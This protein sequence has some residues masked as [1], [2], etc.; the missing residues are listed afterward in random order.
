MLKQ[1]NFRGKEKQRNDRLQ[2][3]E[4][5]LMLE[6]NN[7]AL[8]A[9]LKWLKSLF[10]E[11]TLGT[12]DAEE[13]TYIDG[14]IGLVN[15]EILTLKRNLLL[16][17]S[18]ENTSLLKQIE[19]KSRKLNRVE[20]ELKQGRCEVETVN[21]KH[22]LMLSE[23]EELQQALLSINTN[24]G[25][26]LTTNKKM[27]E[28]MNDQ[29]AKLQKLT[30]ANEVLEHRC[31][32][33]EQGLRKLLQTTEHS[34]LEFS[35]EFYG[36][37]GNV[38]MLEK[39]EEFIS[40]MKGS[41]LKLDK[42]KTTLEDELQKAD[43]K[44]NR[45]LQ[46]KVES[47]EYESRIVK[48]QQELEIQRK[49]E[50][51]SVHHQL[52][53]IKKSYE[54]SL[55]KEEV[56]AQEILKLQKLGKGKEAKVKKFE[57]VI[58]IQEKLLAD[59]VTYTVI[60]QGSI[61]EM[62]LKV[63][64]LGATEQ[65]LR[66]DLEDHL[67]TIAELKGKCSELEQNERDLRQA[68]EMKEEEIQILNRELETSKKSYNVLLQEKEEVEEQC[69][70]I[71]HSLLQT[72]EKLHE[73]ENEVQQLSED[74]EKVR[75]ERENI[76]YEAEKMK[77]VGK[78]KL[79]K[80][81]KFQEIVV[82][83]ENI[84]SE[85]D[86]DLFMMKERINDLSEKL[87]QKEEELQLLQ[88]DLER[89]T[90]W[91]E[92]CK[93]QERTIHDI[94][95][96]VKDRTREFTEGN[97]ESERKI[98]IFEEKCSALE[99]TI[100]FLQRQEKHMEL[101]IQ[102]LSASSSE[103]D[104]WKT[105]CQRL[106]E[107]NESHL[108]RIP[109]VSD[110]IER[111]ET[112]PSLAI[113]PK[114]QED[115]TDD[116]DP[117]YE[118][119]N[120]KQL[121]I[122]L[123]EKQALILS[124][125]DNHQKELAALNA[126]LSKM[127]TL[128][129]AKDA[130]IAKLQNMAKDKQNRGDENGSSNA[131]ES[132]DNLSL[133]SNVVDNEWRRRIMHSEVVMQLERRILNAKEEDLFGLK[134]RVYG[135][136]DW[137]DKEFRGIESSL[138]AMEK[139]SIEK[140][141][142]IASMK[143]EL[144]YLRDISM[145]EEAELLEGKE[146]DV[147]KSFEQELCK[148]KRICKGKEAK[149]NQLEQ[150]KKDLEEKD[151]RNAEQLSTTSHTTNPT[152]W[153]QL[154]ED[155]QD[156]NQKLCQHI[157]TLN[158]EQL[159]RVKDFESMLS[160]ETNQ[161]LTLKQNQRLAELQADC[162]QQEDKVSALEERCNVILMEKNNCEKVLK[163]VNN[164]YQ[165][166]AGQRE[167]IITDMR[168]QIEEK[169]QQIYILEGEKSRL[170]EQLGT[171]LEVNTKQEIEKV[172][173]RNTIRFSEE[174]IQEQNTR[175]INLD[176]TVEKQ[177]AL[178]HKKGNIAEA[179]Q[180]DLEKEI[181][182]LKESLKTIHEELSITKEELEENCNTKNQ[183]QIEQDKLINLKEEVN[184][185]Y[186]ENQHLHSV[187]GG[188]EQQLWSLQNTCSVMKREAGA[189]N[190]HA[191][192]TFEI[193][194]VV[195]EPIIEI[196]SEKLLG[197]VPSSKPTEL[198]KTSDTTQ[199]L[200]D[201]ANETTEQ[202]GE[203][204]IQ[205][206]LCKQQLTDQCSQLELNLEHARKSQGENDSHKQMVMDRLT[207]AQQSVEVL[208]AENSQLQ[209]SLSERM[210]ELSLLKSKLKNT[211]E[212]I[213]K[214]S[215]IV[216]AMSAEQEQSTGNFRE[217]IETSR[218]NIVNLQEQ[219][220]ALELSENNIKAEC[221]QYRLQVCDLQQ[222][223]SESNNV[224]ESERE[225]FLE[226]EIYL[227]LQCKTLFDEVD[228]EKK[229][230]QSLESRIQSVI[231]ELHQEKQRTADLGKEME[232]LQ[233]LKLA[234][235]ELASSMEEKENILSSL[236]DNKN[237]DEEM[238][239]KK[240]KE[241]DEKIASLLENMQ[242]MEEGL[243][244]L[245]QAD[246]MKESLKETKKEDIETEIKSLRAELEKK[247]NFEN[248][249]NDI[250]TDAG[251][252]KKESLLV[253]ELKQKIMTDESSIHILE[254]KLTAVDDLSQKLAECENLLMTREK[255]FVVIQEE[256]ENRVSE[257]SS[258]SLKL[259]DS[260]KTIQD[261]ETANRKLNDKLHMET[262]RL[263]ENIIKA[264]SQKSEMHFQMVT[265][266]EEKTQIQGLLQDKSE[267]CVKLQ[268]QADQTVK[269]IAT[270]D[271]MIN[272]VE[273]LLEQLLQSNE[274][275]SMITELSQKLK[276][277]DVQ[278]AEKD[279]KIE[280][281]DR[282]KDQLSSIIHNV[283][284]CYREVTG[285]ECNVQNIEGIMI[286]LQNFQLKEIEDS[287]HDL[288]AQVAHLKSTIEEMTE[289]ESVRDYICSDLT[290]AVE[291][292]TKEN[293]ALKSGCDISNA[294]CSKMEDDLVEYKQKYSSLLNE[295]ETYKSESEEEEHL[296]QSSANGRCVET[297]LQTTKEKLK[298]ME[299]AY[300]QI[301]S[302]LKS[303]EG[304][305]EKMLVK[306]KAF[307]TKC[308]KLQEEVN[309][310]KESS[311]QVTN[312]GNAADNTLKEELALRI[313]ELEETRRKVETS[314]WYISEIEKLKENEGMLETTIGKQSES[315]KR[316]IGEIDLLKNNLQ[317]KD[318]R[319]QKKEKRVKEFENEREQMQEE[320]DG[321][322]EDVSEMKKEKNALKDEY[323]SLDLKLKEVLN[324]NKGLK[325]KIGAIEWRLEE[326]ESL[327]EELE[328]VRSELDRKNSDLNL[329]TKEKEKIQAELEQSKQNQ[330]NPSQH[331]LNE[332]IMSLKE[333][334][335]KK[336][337]MNKDLE[338]Q[339]DSFREELNETATEIDNLRG[340]LKKS[341]KGVEDQT[342]LLREEL[343]QPATENEGLIKELNL[344]REKYNQVE[345]IQKEND[346][347]KTE[348]EV[349]KRDESKST[350]TISGAG[351]E[352]SN[353]MQELEEEL[354]LIKEELNE[355]MSENEKLRSENG[356]DYKAILFDKLQH[357]YQNL[358]AEV[359]SMKKSGPSNVR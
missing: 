51:K 57:D 357:E 145:T 65:S 312:E 201:Y 95:Q 136:E 142:I 160:E 186:E 43:K 191:E 107:G 265:L 250:K 260:D 194:N 8:D 64:D 152:E 42:E 129:K 205:L 245:D 336:M 256:L 55:E 262:E 199:D 358:R 183:L 342:R 92:V 168:Q 27:K 133:N 331:T 35:D 268:A 49:E 309:V 94:H 12:D 213:E 293:D 203:K 5:E 172:E 90:H 291:N 192:E 227:S 236:I 311:A 161:I 209:R 47:K 310:L 289:R 228:Q 232:Q 124:M 339:G 2:C 257:L 206:E 317:Q 140:Y 108:K 319:F 99:N 217:E 320:I 67:K 280:E 279:K 32:G 337:E 313:Q 62:N 253:T 290:L 117:E 345:I 274:K 356:S 229:K 169:K 137:Y 348:L 277:L 252:E 125:Q 255:D 82:K 283:K 28:E 75:K 353:R 208:S 333:E 325:E 6:K 335:D 102:S 163:E 121:I 87:G 350:D 70:K 247:G 233:K 305:C 165:E 352:T 346:K 190:K 231:D 197:A 85:K 128:C 174:K 156:E 324:E 24:S 50:L 76:I 286:A 226:S 1:D 298:S 138:A 3:E 29:Q 177:T 338:D 181:V 77:K 318:E 235:D 127:K 239:L 80:L 328:E 11:L 173:L 301:H 23:Y 178:M 46:H 334:L 244:Q 308:D 263:T 264:E 224:L 288:L 175:I 20:E 60:L 281:F 266:E 103:A 214:F 132:T 4:F 68:L 81:R 254:E 176:I 216:Q 315:E 72:K 33:Y 120:P 130:K 251:T 153:R 157:E 275:D 149:I 101:E 139:S 91:E 185:L 261:L 164:S 219:I 118:D 88:G 31:D 271:K 220:H 323:E 242:E 170:N 150:A 355:T 151:G 258:L 58:N 25:I 300:E 9:C 292:L 270:K 110:L 202:L 349:L 284:G 14:W 89:M 306:L 48:L 45:L 354:E 135:W 332:D 297:E 196:S 259:T 96:S 143:E 13:T 36:R 267:E 66:S 100:E 347:L 193:S 187:V 97:I 218:T 211:E 166:K 22:Y 7:T 15:T 179:L 321:F 180:N 351:T 282:K 207:E 78:G 83:Q 56:K 79:T 299:D 141:T 273:S 71:K 86:T 221:E 303:S 21:S 44:E 296:N 278:L 37:D 34:S 74:L 249:S 326:V 243:N 104:D 304:K 198:M 204:I 248:E 287:N 314:Q 10:K 294:K 322:K 18:E 269:D 329:T 155:S 98:S 116:N 39:L 241:K 330:N 73:S 26:T 131:R 84:S 222:Q 195:V 237:S 234:S 63:E 119:L 59:K 230:N 115:S 223:C 16:N 189:L 54:S 212:S 52:Q 30:E 344:I 111:Q 327:E 316:L 109:I 122:T 158:T 19:A 162:K 359:E 238:M 225:K 200:R 341:L 184:R 105:R 276:N 144:D 69:G 272:D 134:E 112:N 340:E 147:H 123:D 38:S 215:G 93:Q 106:E 171:A 148:L 210:E 343:H 188:K 41:M 295:N 61:S 182:T 17:I 53:E 126:K 40:S 240:L 307:K 114:I 285:D 159:Q 302:R 246:K 154:L 146:T 167:M 113:K